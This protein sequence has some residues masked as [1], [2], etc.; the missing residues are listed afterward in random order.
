M[1]KNLLICYNICLIAIFLFYV[2]CCW[3]NWPVDLILKINPSLIKVGSILPIIS[4]MLFGYQTF[5]HRSLLWYLSSINMASLSI[6]MLGVNYVLTNLLSSISQFKWYMMT[7]FVMYFVL[8]T[9]GIVCK[10]NILCAHK[11]QHN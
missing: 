1:K 2:T 9:I 3:I 4:L 7:L 6:V 8:M 10:K 5:V 11:E